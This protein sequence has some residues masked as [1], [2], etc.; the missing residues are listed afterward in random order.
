M[1][2]AVDSPQALAGDQGGSIKS[3]ILPNLGI[4]LDL[5]RSTHKKL[6]TP[7][8]RWEMVGMRWGWL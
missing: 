4:H 2:V 8:M 5:H 6:N 1:F 3:S 7:G